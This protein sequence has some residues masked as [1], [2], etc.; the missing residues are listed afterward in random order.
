MTIEDELQELAKEI[1]QEEWDALRPPCGEDKTC[2][3]CV[4]H[5]ECEWVK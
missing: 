3:G 4:E 5:G 1:P 2:S